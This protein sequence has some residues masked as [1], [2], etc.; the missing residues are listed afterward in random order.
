MSDE[1]TLRIAGR[2]RES[3]V[4]GPGI[5]YVVFTQG[6]PHRCPGCHNPHTWPMEGGEET[7]VS[8]LLAEIRLDPLLQGVT[9]SG[10]EPFLQAGALAELAEAVRFEGLD[11]WTYTGY[12][13]EELMENENPAWKLLLEQSD[14]LVDGR[15]EQLLR[16][17]G[18]RFRG[19]SNQRLIDVRNSLILGSA[20]LWG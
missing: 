17:Y 4:D 16:S 9:L 8:S 14:V 13:W 3:I 11:V 1:Q 15:Y 10:G 19:S 12:T 6:C 7:T 5:R 20:V 18:A 2:L